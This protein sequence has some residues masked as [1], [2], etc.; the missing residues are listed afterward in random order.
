MGLM[1]LFENALNGQETAKTLED[2][3]LLRNHKVEFTVGS[4][5][6][7]GIRRREKHDGRMRQFQEKGLSSREAK[8]LVD[9]LAKRDDDFID[10]RISCAECR[11]YYAGKCGLNVTLIGETTIFSL[12]RCNGFQLE[13]GRN[14]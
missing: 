2:H 11:H 13:W 4:V 14:D 12:V 1:A 6:K 8:V 5:E 9:R 7:A 10:D 3:N